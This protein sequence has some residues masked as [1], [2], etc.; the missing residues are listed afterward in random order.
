M[1]GVDFPLPGSSI[2]SPPPGKV[3]VYLKSLDV[4]LFLPL[5]D[6]WEEVLRKEGCSIQMLTPN[7]VNKVVAFEMIR[8]ANGVLPDYFVFKY[9]FS[10]YCTGDKCTFSIRRWGTHWFLMGRP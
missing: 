5:T 3:G 4:G 2:T 6:F 9:F 7:T 8:Y 10:F 1:D